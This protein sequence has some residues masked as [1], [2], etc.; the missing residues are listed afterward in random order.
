[1]AVPKSPNVT[2]ASTVQVRPSTPAHHGLV[3]LILR[4]IIRSLGSAALLACLIAAAVILVVPG[5]A[6]A[7][8]DCPDVEVIF[9][10]GTFEPPGI[11]VTGQGF[12]DALRDRLPDQSLNVHA[13]NYPASVSYTHLTLPTIALLCRSRWSPYH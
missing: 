4:Y 10:R 1:M 6:A 2:L 7:A 5:A 3:R 9:A 8:E 12:I 13:V 11:G